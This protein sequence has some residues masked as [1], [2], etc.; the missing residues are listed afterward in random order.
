M[1]KHQNVVTLIDEDT[2]K[3][4]EQIIICGQNFQSDL[5]E[6]EELMSE[7][8]DAIN[9]VKN[10]R[11]TSIL[12]IIASSGGIL[13]GIFGASTTKGTDR[14]EYAS[15]TLADFLALVAN[16]VDIATQNKLLQQFS[17]NMEEA[18]KLQTEIKEEIDKLREKYSQLTTKHFS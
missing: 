11:N 7:I 1:R 14:L 8:K 17:E 15:A 6:V 13:L 10:E 2:D 5:D 12:N 3:E 18:K 4:I 16:G 9:G